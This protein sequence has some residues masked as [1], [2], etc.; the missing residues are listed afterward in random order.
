MKAGTTEQGK[1]G[2]PYHYLCL[3]F[4]KTLAGNAICRNFAPHI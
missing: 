2:T 1:N 3:F 4:T